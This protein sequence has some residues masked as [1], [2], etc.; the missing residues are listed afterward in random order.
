MDL[1]AAAAVERRAVETRARAGT[2]TRP[3]SASPNPV[4]V[5][6]WSV[7]SSRVVIRWQP[8]PP[9]P[10]AHVSTSASN[11][12]ILCSSA[13]VGVCTVRPPAICRCVPAVRVTS[14][15][16]EL[17]HERS[18]WKRRD[19][20]GIGHREATSLVRFTFTQ[21]AIQRST[22]DAQDARSLGLVAT[23]GLDDLSHVRT[24]DICEWH[25]A[26]GGNA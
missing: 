4:T 18:C 3:W 15:A 25:S 19:R 13:R 14:Y 2:S 26:S 5:R 12:A 20:A 21:L 9:I 23:R 7:S 24:L 16:D 8:A 10:T 17:P 1:R 6:V 11:R 22:I